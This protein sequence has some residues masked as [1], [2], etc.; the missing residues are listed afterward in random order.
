[1]I[2]YALCLFLGLIMSTP[3]LAQASEPEFEA[4]NALAYQGDY[5]GAVAAYEAILDAG[6]NDSALF[7]NLGNAQYRLGSY[8][9]AI[10]SYRRGLNASPDEV[11]SESLVHNLELARSALQ[12]RYRASNDGSQFIYT[13]PVGWLYQLSHMTSLDLLLYSFL[14]LWWCLA[15]C[16]IARRFYRTL[17][18]S[19]FIIPIGVLVIL[20]GGLLVARVSTDQSF[21]LGVVVA[22]EVVMR[23]GPDVHAR[24]VDVPEGMEVRLIDSSA[25]WRKIEI[26][27]GRSGW[28]TDAV[29]RAL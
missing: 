6:I 17:S 5:K 20:V 27:S 22:D 26:P 9:Q 2:P 12:A 25:G 4:A 19:S 15:A 1:M 16:L 10:W 14:A 18:W 3:V 29:F 7:M 28:V 23:E 11:L 24:G 8:G 13:E 21:T